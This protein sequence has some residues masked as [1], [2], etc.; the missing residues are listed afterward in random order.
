MIVIT[1]ALWA[2]IGL[3]FY[4]GPGRPWNQP[5][6]RLGGGSHRPLRVVDAV[7]A[8]SWARSETVWQRWLRQGLVLAALFCFAMGVA[9]FFGRYHLIIDGHST[10]VAGGSYTDVHFWLPAYEL[11]IVCWFAAAVLLLAA[12]GVP[13]LRFWLFARPS[14]LLLPCGL[15]AVLYIGAIVVPPAVEQLYV[16]P[17][18][19]TLE[20]PFLLRSIAGTREAYNLDGPSV[21][22]REFAVSAT[23]LTREDLDKNAPTL[24]EVRIWDWR[25]LDPQLQ[26][27]QGLRPYYRF[28][29]VDIDRYMID[30]AERQVMIT[31]RELDI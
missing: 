14:H 2:V 31:A 28:A 6:F 26:Q 9:R 25:A 22:E 15:F 5:A 19:I 1:I 21:E 18:Q 11:I 24:Q 10:V 7:D 29:G 16:G 23:P 13:R 8:E 12:A 4:P 17:N 20:R 27:T 3:R 30:G